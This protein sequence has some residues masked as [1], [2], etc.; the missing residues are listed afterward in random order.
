MDAPARLR[1]WRGDRSLVQASRDLD[2]DPSALHLWETAQRHP[3]EHHREVIQR[4]VGIP[5]SAWGGVG[6]DASTKRPNVNDNK[7]KRASGKG[8]KHGTP[9]TRTKVQRSKASRTRSAAAAIDA[10]QQASAPRPE[11]S[12]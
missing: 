10:R 3:R 2:C 7:P 6:A 5:M 8:A 1:A 12:R 4:V 9:K 11:A